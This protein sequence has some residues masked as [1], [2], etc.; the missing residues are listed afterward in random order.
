[1]FLKVFANDTSKI[2]SFKLSFNYKK[3]DPSEIYELYMK[4]AFNS[5]VGEAQDSQNEFD[6]NMKLIIFSIVGT[7][8]TILVILIIGLIVYYF[9]LQK[10]QSFNL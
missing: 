6:K 7:S 9:R 8:G 2:S 5:A 3:K 10:V 4:G 1:M